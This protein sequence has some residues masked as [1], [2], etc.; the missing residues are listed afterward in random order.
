MA[1]N[2]KLENSVNNFGLIEKPVYGKLNGIIDLI[3]KLISFI[4]T[5]THT[6]NTDDLSDGIKLGRDAIDIST[7]NAVGITGS[8]F[9]PA[10]IGTGHTAA[11]AVVIWTGNSCSEMGTGWSA[12]KD[13]NGTPWGK[14]KVYFRAVGEGAG[15]STNEFGGSNTHTHDI[16]HTHI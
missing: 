1:Y 11:R 14:E 2:D 16:T 5:H 8:G 9:V 6:G 7:F 13:I 10:P 4:K 12:A 15:N 3:N